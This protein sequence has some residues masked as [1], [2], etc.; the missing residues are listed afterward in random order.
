MHASVLAQAGVRANETY[1]R[2]TWWALEMIATKVSP[3]VGIQLKPLRDLDWIE[4]MS[5]RHALDG[6]LRPGINVF[7]DMSQVDHIDA[8]GMSALVG[9]IRR[10]RAVAGD[11]ELLNVR[12]NARRRLELV[13]IYPFLLPPL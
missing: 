8:E 1:L 12:P 5:L 7:I 9:S 6:V 4:A 10:V 3:S 13:G 11:V 2:P